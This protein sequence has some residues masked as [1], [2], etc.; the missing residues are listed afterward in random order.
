MSRL[1]AALRRRYRTAAEAL[2]ALG[3]DQSLLDPRGEVVGDARPPLYD[4]GKDAMTTRFT[5]ARRMGRDEAV[6]EFRSLLDDPEADFGDIVAA[7]IEAAGEGQQ[8]EIHQAIR[9]MGEDT[10][11]PRSWARDRME[12]RRLSKDSDARLRRMGRDVEDPLRDLEPRGSVSGEDRR[13]MAGDRRLAMDSS[14][15]GTFSR[16]FPTAVLPERA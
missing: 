14:P 16:I 5:R 2:E 12:R 6:E 4:E 3:L 9:E 1:L 15:R 8:E 10:R 7:A 13:P 11:G